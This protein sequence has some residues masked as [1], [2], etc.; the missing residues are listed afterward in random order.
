MELKRCID[1]QIDTPFYLYKFLCLGD[2][3]KVSVIASFE[4]SCKHWL[5]S[6]S[7]LC[8]SSP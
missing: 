4:N 7:I 5:F 2:F 6:Y 3:S 8:R 1:S